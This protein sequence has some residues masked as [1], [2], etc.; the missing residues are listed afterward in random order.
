VSLSAVDGNDIVGHVLFSQLSVPGLQAASLAPVAVLPERQGQGIGS[1]LITRGLEAC[2]GSGVDVAL[3]VG[4]PAYYTKF[5][6]SLST[7]AQ[8]VCPY[9]GPYLLALELQP[10]VL[11]AAQYD[12]EYPAPFRD[13]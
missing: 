4:E 12:V 9:L 7:G 5:G 3:V 2:R 6:F 11:G 1:A 10:G 13:L 8:F